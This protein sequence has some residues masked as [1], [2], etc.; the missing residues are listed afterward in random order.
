M[1]E[2]S[3]NFDGTDHV[4]LVLEYSR[5]NDDNNDQT[6][7]FTQAKNLL[8]F[9]FDVIDSSRTPPTVTLS[10]NSTSFSEDPDDEPSTQMGD[11]KTITLTTTDIPIGTVLNWE[12]VH[13][14]VGDFRSSSQDFWDIDNDQPYSSSSNIS[15]Q[16][17]VSDAGTYGTENGT[18]SFD[19]AVYGDLF[20]ENESEYFK[21]FIRGSG[22][23]FDRDYTNVQIPGGAQ[24]FTIRDTSQTP[25]IVA[26]K[27]N[28]S[29]LEGDNVT[30]NV[31][32]GFITS[33]VYWR[34]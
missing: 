9:D 22:Y 25:Y 24:S 10:W 14:G 18:A 5:P 8:N 15:G 34:F 16:V 26:D 1:T 23:I 13:T 33:Q 28:Y 17:T 12:V 6:I 29:V 11:R 4:R 27:D 31:T 21:I 20:T 7:E 32:S 3:A 2:A 30:I 19:L